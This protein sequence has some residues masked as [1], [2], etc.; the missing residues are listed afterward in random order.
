M[1]LHREFFAAVDSSAFSP[2]PVEQ[3]SASPGGDHLVAFTLRKTA[4]LST[5]GRSYPKSMR[6]S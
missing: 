5:L 2:V 1:L 3:L 4:W 6:A